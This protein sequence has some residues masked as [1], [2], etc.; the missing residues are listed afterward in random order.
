VSEK[1]LPN[2][3]GR[4]TLAHARSDLQ[5]IEGLEAHLDE[6]GAT[7]AS[8][9]RD[10]IAMVRWNADHVIAAYNPESPQQ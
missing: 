4:D 5:Y 10:L 2:D 7:S 1:L 8:N 6:G 9:I 3:G